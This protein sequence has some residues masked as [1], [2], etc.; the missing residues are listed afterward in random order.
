MQTMQPDQTPPPHSFLKPTAMKLPAP[1][2]GAWNW[3]SNKEAGG[4]GIHK[5]TIMGQKS[6]DVLAL[7]VETD[8]GKVSALSE[9]TQALMKQDVKLSDADK[10]RYG[11]IYKDIAGLQR[12]AE[13][14][15]R[16]ELGIDPAVQQVFHEFGAGRK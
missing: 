3:S 1:K 9:A 2:I 7:C 5:S 15:C 11:R 10:A 6:A 4:N 13:D 12:A 8:A 16:A 14:S